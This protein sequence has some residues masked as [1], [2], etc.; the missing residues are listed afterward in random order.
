MDTPAGLIS[1]DQVR[2]TAGP[3]PRP[4][5]IAGER[6]ELDHRLANSLQ[7][8]ADF[9]IFEQ[10]RIADPAAQVALLEAAARL[11][12]VGQLHRFLSDHEEMRDVNLQPFLIGLCRLVEGGTGLACSVDAESVAVPGAAAQQLAIAINELA[13]NAAKH[14]YRKGERG[15]L[16]IDCHRDG[17]ILR[18]TV[19][20]EG[21]GLRQ[22]FSAEQATG[23]GM[24]I[25]K[26]VVRQLR[27]TL[28]AH[29]DHGARFTITLP[30]SPSTPLLTR[31]FSPRV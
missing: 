3:L 26:A 2:S 18:L 21:A 25:L 12:A 17:A 22:D 16:H 4:Q 9:L 1:T 13:M 29:N 19:A 10:T 27:G 23:L 30:L 24:S 6:R 14:A 15:A 31:S 5:P 20:D 8:A 7:L 28:E 11:S